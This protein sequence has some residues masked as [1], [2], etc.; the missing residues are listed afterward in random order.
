VAGVITGAGDGHIGANSGQT[1]TVSGNIGGSAPLVTIAGGTV[2]LT[3][4]NTYSGG[5]MV[6]QGTTVLLNN[7][8]GATGGYML[9]TNN[10]NTST[11]N[12]GSSSQTAPTTVAMSA[13]SAS[14]MG[15]LYPA[16][17]ANNS[18]Q[19]L[20]VSGVSGFPTT[21]T[22]AGSMVVG[23]N[24]SMTI[25]NFAT[26]NQNGGLNIAAY[27]GFGATVNVGNGL[28]SSGALNYNA[29]SAIQL[30]EFISH[31]SA[32]V[33]NING[34][35]L[36][37]TQPFNY[38]G[39]STNAGAVGRV[40]IYN[41]G[42][43]TLA[44]SIPQLTTGDASGQLQLGTN[45]NINMGGNTSTLS[46]GLANVSGQVGSLNIIGGGT[47]TLAGTN[48]YTGT[49]LVSNSTVLVSSTGVLPTNSIT[50]ATNA[51][52]GGVGLVRGATTI[53]DGTLK[54]GTSGIGTLTISNSLT[55][56]ANSTFRALVSLAGGVTNNNA[57][58]GLGTVNYGGTLSIT[59]VGGTPLTAG[60]QFKL[61]TASG[62]AGNF[63]SIVDAS[64]ATWSFS[65]AT[66]IATVLTVP[67]TVN[68][69]STNIISTIS[70]N[71]LTLQWPADHIGW[72]LQSNSVSLADTNFWFN[73]PGSDT[74]NLVNIIL[75]PAQPNVFYRMK[76]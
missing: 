65:P 63:A 49:T 2:N 6:N 5:L 43:L 58:V 57:V 7:Q 69:N 8:S 53:Q 34:G 3:G 18:F 60:A 67:V 73:V 37:T 13:A 26:W 72:F 47:L 19:S 41:G 44:A 14:Q 38:S 35:V 51:T 29:S 50:V 27:G 30:T 23:R 74:T 39:F 28:G 16:G 15:T 54:P 36:T 21:V 24:S 71:T 68:T 22:N 56:N 64:G 17:A 66:G 55:F 45:A 40:V 75:N 31:S 9:C 12:M 4:A 20:S 32:S 62:N 52:L 10:A 48:S 59:N 33:L 11:L 1:G 42:T 46:I 76:Y 25:G 70:G 61:F